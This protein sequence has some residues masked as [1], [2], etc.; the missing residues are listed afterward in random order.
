MLRICQVGVSHPHPCP[1]RACLS[2]QRRVR[3]RARAVGGGVWYSCTGPFN[4]TSAVSAKALA[5][6]EDW[7]RSSNVQ[8]AS[9]FILIKNLMRTLTWF[10]CFTVALVVTADMKHQTKSICHHLCRSW[11]P[12]VPSAQIV[13]DLAS[14]Q[15]N[16]VAK[17]GEGVTPFHCRRHSSCQH[18][19]PFCALEAKN[20]GRNDTAPK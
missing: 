7:P 16:T 14:C 5:C 18:H 9:V 2:R 17:G 11:M 20:R 13:P 8:R 15:I 6:T 4:I 12:V 10:S 1:S 3:V 19:R